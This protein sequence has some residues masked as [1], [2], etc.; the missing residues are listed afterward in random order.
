M[1]IDS[2]EFTQKIE[3]IS[4]RGIR[5]AKMGRPRMNKSLC[6]TKSQG[7]LFKFTKE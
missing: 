7:F 1:V 5:P 3:A 4:G 6:I 2:E